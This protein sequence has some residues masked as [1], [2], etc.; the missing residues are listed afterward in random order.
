[1]YKICIWPKEIFQNKWWKTKQTTEFECFWYFLLFYITV[2][3]SDGNL[4]HIAHVWCKNRTHVK[5][6]QICNCSWFNQIP[7]TDQI[8]GIV[9]YLFYFWVTIWYLV[10]CSVCTLYKARIPSPLMVCLAQSKAP[11]YNGL[12]NIIFVFYQKKIS[13]LCK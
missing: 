8:N 9:P 11:V 10:P 4:E 6:N 2:L 12:L 7:L 1:M 5:K 3:I 13:F